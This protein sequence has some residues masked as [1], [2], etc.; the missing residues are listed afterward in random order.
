MPA[1]HDRH[2]RTPAQ[3]PLR[4]DNVHKT[5]GLIGHENQD[6]GTYDIARCHEH[7]DKPQKNRDKSHYAYHRVAVAA[8]PEIHC[9]K[10]TFLNEVK[11]FI[12]EHQSKA[13]TGSND[14]NRKQKKPSLELHA[15]IEPFQ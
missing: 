15:G 14:P 13:D 5:L 10:N 2:R 9:P 6:D 12:I 4:I 11:I 8:L 1:A 7:E 3:F